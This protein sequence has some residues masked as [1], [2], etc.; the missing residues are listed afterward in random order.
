M[1]WLDEIVSGGG[2]SPW[3]RTRIEV[4]GRD[5]KSVLHN[6]CTNHIEKLEAGSGCEAF[7]LNVKGK[8]V[9]FANVLQRQDSL[10][11]ETAVDQYERLVQQLDRYVISEDVTFVNLAEKESQLLVIGSQGLK[12]IGVASGELCPLHELQVSLADTDVRVIGLPWSSNCAALIQFDR[13]REEAVND[14]LNQLAFSP[15]TEEQVEL[16]RVASGY[17]I[18]ERDLT[19]DNLPQEMDRDHLAID[20]QKGC[21]L[22]QETVARI[23]AMGHVNRTLVGIVSPQPGELLGSDLT[24]DGKVVGSISSAVTS[25][26]DGITIGLAL[27][28][29]GSNQPGQKLNSAV[30]EVEVKSL[31]MDL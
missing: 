9:G 2:W 7:F 31:P 19:E 18:F 24:S 5:A 16:V 23:D 8:I 30:G 10:V 15:L 22:G 12:S 13:R 20:F 21:Y 6:F 25:A 28:R 27:V 26:T 29:R 3:P 11:I 4:R 1:K 14:V 17:P